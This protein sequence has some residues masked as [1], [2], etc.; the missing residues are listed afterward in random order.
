MERSE[1]SE[2]YLIGSGGHAKQVI[3]ILPLGPRIMGIFDDQKTGEW[4]GYPI[5]GTLDDLHL[6]IQVKGPE[7]VNLF[8][9]I[10]DNQ[11]RR[12]IMNRFHDCNW[13]N[14]IAKDAKISKSVKLGN[15]NY[16]G[17][18]VKILADTIIGDGNIINESATVTHDIIIGNWN[19]IAP[20]TV[21]CGNVTIS[22]LNL[23]GANSTLIPKIKIGHMNIFGA[24]SVINKDIGNFGK[25]VGVPIRYLSQNSYQ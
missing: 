18:G 10:G 23:F 11:T 8:C 7:K 12:N 24:G 3:D 25:Y 16:I 6:M 15:G 2:I 19:H 20:G 14:C 21:I 9:C 4:Y 1:V 5:L 22:D 13:I 17:Q